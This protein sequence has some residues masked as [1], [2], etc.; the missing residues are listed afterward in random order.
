MHP[1]F[2]K[3]TLVRN[4]PG[5]TYDGVV[6]DR[7]L[8]LRLSDGGELSVFD[9]DEPLSE[10]L[11][12]GRTYQLVLAVSAPIGI[13]TGASSRPDAKWTGRVIEP[14]WRAIDLN[15][16]RARPELLDRAWILLESGIGELLLNPR[17]LP[18][19]SQTGENIRWDD[20]RFDLY[21]VVGP[22][23]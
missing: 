12:V 1:K 5:A 22:V 2:V 18:G 3:A 20:A 14:Q 21:G 15:L 7:F 4:D 17:D 10:G 11:E 23:D 19:P 13:R 16:A 9:M 8:T 6:Y